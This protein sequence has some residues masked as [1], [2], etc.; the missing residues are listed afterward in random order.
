MC[1][2]DRAI[3]ASV[4]SPNWVL[5]A[6]RHGLPLWG[7]SSKH[8]SGYTRPDVLKRARCSP[9]LTCFGASGWTS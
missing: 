4:V 2:R 9:G 5:F 7:R 6:C 1:I 3:N 8:P